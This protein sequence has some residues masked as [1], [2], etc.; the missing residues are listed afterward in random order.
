MDVW[1]IR[2]AHAYVL[3][4][5]SRLTCGAAAGC[6]R[7]VG[8]PSLPVDW[9]SQR[10]RR[11]STTARRAPPAAQSFLWAASWSTHC[12]QIRGT[13]F[14]RSG[15]S[16][17]EMNALQLAIHRCRMR[18][19][20]MPGQ[21]AN[22]SFQVRKAKAMSADPFQQSS[23]AIGMCQGSWASRCFSSQSRTSMRTFHLHVSRGCS[24]QPMWR[25]RGVPCALG[26]A[27]LASSVRGQQR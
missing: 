12:P 2:L 17:I 15:A 21:I 4:S 19:A 23:H 13:G 24:A 14:N 22:C 16:Y 18:V 7:A 6:R 27:L 25:T 10:A 11:S 20:R 1:G 9:R 5:R 26:R 3:C 8:L